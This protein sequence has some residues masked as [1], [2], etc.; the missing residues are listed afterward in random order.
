VH[1]H[2]IHGS[3][4]Y[5]FF[6]LSFFFLFI[7]GRLDSLTAVSRRTAAAA[8]YGFDLQA[9]SISGISGHSHL[10]ESGK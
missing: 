5:L 4:F 3:Y 9:D 1:P 7:T 8:V 10:A 2:N 6:S